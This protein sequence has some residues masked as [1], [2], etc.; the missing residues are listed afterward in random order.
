MVYVNSNIHKTIFFLKRVGML[1]KIKVRNLVN[2]SGP[3]RSSINF[4]SFILTFSPTKD[5][6]NRDANDVETQLM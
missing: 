2:S 6:V 4:A 3:M 1:G 5:S